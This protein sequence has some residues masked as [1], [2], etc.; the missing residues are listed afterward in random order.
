M[1]G[2]TAGRLCRYCG[3]TTWPRGSTVVSPRRARWWCRTK[4]GSARP[5]PPASPVCVASVLG[6]DAAVRHLNALG[7]ILQLPGLWMRQNQLMGSLPDEIK[8]LEWWAPVLQQ[9]RLKTLKSMVTGFSRMAA[10]I[11]LKVDGY[12]F[13]TPATTI[14]PC[15]SVCP[16]TTSSTA[17]SAPKHCPRLRVKSYP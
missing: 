9:T 7:H 15:W 13:A 14:A 10:E 6:S 3:G 11:P 5:K 8:M 2:E 16:R 4:P 17:R 1:A 12:R